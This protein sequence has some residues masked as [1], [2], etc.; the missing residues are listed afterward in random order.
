MNAIKPLI[1]LVVLGGVGYG[2]YCSLMKEPGEPPPGT[3]T[4]ATGPLDIKLDEGVSLPGSST[5]AKSSGP[6][7]LSPSGGTQSPPFK[8]LTSGGNAPAF[9]P[10]PSKTSASDPASSTSSA[11]NTRDSAAIGGYGSPF[12]SIPGGTSTDTPTSSNGSAAATTSDPPP[13]DARAA[14]GNNTSTTSAAPGSFADAWNQAHKKLGAGQLADA[15][16]DL[17]AW[18]G[19]SSLTSAEETQLVDLLGQLAGTVI[20]SRQHLIAEPHKVQ[21]GEQLADVAAKY[22]VTPELLAKINGL[23]VR[24]PLAG[25]EELKIVKGPFSA[26]V[27]V[28]RRRLVLLLDGRYAGSFDLP[29]VG[30]DL[31]NLGSGQSVELAVSKKTVAPIYNGPQGE[32]AAGASGNPLG[33]YLLAL[34]NELAIHGT[35]PNGAPAE[36]PAA[37]IRLGATDIEDLFDIL[38]V[39]SRVIVRR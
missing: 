34:G 27:D 4:T 39:G 6:N 36:Q 26:M 33:Q 16:K 7:I 21:A 29:A 28:Q 9:T 22:Q 31:N 24:A 25:G 13:F 5:A 2:V 8:G 11:T 30:S 19:H 20:Y 18:Y 37:G 15:L 1:L 10:P 23:D 17:S 3:D 12:P 32:I 14:L 38:T 35:N